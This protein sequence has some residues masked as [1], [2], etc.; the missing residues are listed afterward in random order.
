MKNLFSKSTIYGVDFSGSKKACKKIWICESVPT[1]EGLKVQECWNL[2]KKCEKK[3]EEKCVNPCDKPFEILTEFIASNPQAIFGLDFPFG[4]PECLLCEN[5]WESFVKRFHEQY[6]NPT[7]FYNDSHSRVEKEPKRLTDIDAK[8]PMSP[9]FIHLHKQTYYG[10]S[11][12]LYSLNFENF[13]SIH[14][15]QPLEESK[16]WVIE[17]CPASTLKF[18]NLYRNYKKKGKKAKESK[19]NRKFILQ[20]LIDKKLITDI[21]PEAR[22]SAVVDKEGDALDSII[23][24]VATHRAL[25]NNFSVSDHELYELEGHIYI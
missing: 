21:S 19:N 18:E 23:A 20:G 13:A 24:A 25:K 7:Q 2:E 1:D 6:K 9:I 11:N 3:Y 5:D 14:P 4:L 8:S 12:V 16:P 10:I 17:I 22:E 15:M